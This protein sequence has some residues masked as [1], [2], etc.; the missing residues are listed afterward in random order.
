MPIELVLFLRK[1]IEWSAALGGYVGK[2]LGTRLEVLSI[3]S[4]ILH[5][6][7][8]RCSRLL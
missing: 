8:V 2:A 5:F 3:I 4:D 1:Q 6:A 7:S